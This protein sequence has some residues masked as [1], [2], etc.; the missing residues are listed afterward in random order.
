MEIFDVLNRWAEYTKFDPQQTRFNLLSSE[1]ELNRVNKRI[2]RLTEDYDHTG[3]AA[4]I[5]AKNVCR[6]LL[7]EK[8][9]T[10]YEVATSLQDYQDSLDMW[11]LFTSEDVLAIEN[12]Y[13][14]ALNKIVQQIVG[15]AM[16]GE[17]DKALERESMCRAVDAVVEELDTCNIDLFLRGG[18]IRPLK[19]FSTHIQVFEQL[20][21]CL[22]ALEM[23]PDDSIYLCYI[24]N[25]GTADGYFGFYLKSNG[26]ILSVNER[27][28]EA[29]PGQHNHSRNNRWAESKKY[30][31]FPYGFM[32]QYT[33]HDY[34]GYARKHLIDDER[35]D[36]CRLDPDAYLPLV[37]GM[38][39]LSSKF[40]GRDLFEYPLKFTDSLL[41]INVALPVP[42]ETA[43]SI[44]ENSAIA[45]AHRNLEINLSSESVLAGTRGKQ[46]DYQENRQKSGLETGVF[47]EKENLFVKLYGEGFELD[48]SKLLEA[49][50]QLKRLTSAEI[51]VRDEAPNVEFVGTRDRME[52]IAYMNARKQ[53][54]EYIRDKMFEE[55]QQFG[56]VA[57]V[58][59]WWENALKA[60]KDKVFRMCCE[61][62][63][64]VLCGNEKNICGNYWRD[65][66]ENKLSFLGFQEDCRG[67]A[68]VYLGH[69]GYVFNQP[70]GYRGRYLDGK[71]LCP[72]TGKLASTFFV[73]SPATWEELELIVG[74][75][76]LPKILMGWRSDG[77]L[78]VGNPLLDATDKVFEVGTP[79][80]DREA[81]I[82]KRYWTKKRWDDFYFHN[83]SKCPDWLSREP[84][85]P[86]LE[87]APS[88]SFKFAVGFSK[89]GFK[90]LLK[91][92][93][94]DEDLKTGVNSQKVEIY[95]GKGTKKEN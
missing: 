44:P 70:H 69:S 24:N 57:A 1:Y 67:S 74:A 75:G 42:G 38:V 65:A 10:L 40:S 39:M 48:V 21:E 26:T 28:D 34:K 23:A 90:R 9:V 78:G 20:A 13:L 41:S 19:H 53:L 11:A 81:S 88:I 66:S 5:Y 73:F 22:L 92:F 17:R 76:T 4:V 63:R 8:K 72:I 89:I 31:L 45:V 79:F 54:A 30:N 43:L 47:P 86:V 51:A 14:D 94:M 82:N 36:F 58:R 3:A 52:M 50:P 46:F 35:L 49:N 6:Q 93:G 95:H 33:E 84:E 64:L 12:T 71:W 55:Y 61:K 29:Y 91:Q 32:F 16:L 83:A 7:Q 77:H 27:V 68:D 15:P 87:T 37:L 85:L 80:E 60:S 2:M 59:Q 25:N 56:G 18:P 62:Y